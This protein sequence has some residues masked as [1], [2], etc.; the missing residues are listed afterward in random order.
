M[1][2]YEELKYVL[3]GATDWGYEYA[4]KEDVE[5]AFAEL[6]E[7]HAH[8]KMKRCEKM[9]HYCAIKALYEIDYKGNPDKWRFYSKWMHKWFELAEYFRDLTKKM[10]VK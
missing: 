7:Q 3:S 5:A 2:K 8:Q 4:K 6:E 1:S 10:E 9:W